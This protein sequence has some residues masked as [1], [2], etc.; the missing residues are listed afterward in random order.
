MKMSMT[1]RAAVAAASI[2]LLLAG[3]AHDPGAPAGNDITD[4]PA[5]TVVAKS[6]AA[7][8]AA[9]SYRVEVHNDEKSLPL[10]LKFAVV[11]T[12]L[13]G[14]VARQGG[15]TEILKVGTNF[16]IRPDE[17]FWRTEF[18][19]AKEAHAYAAFTGTR[20]IKI[21]RDDRWI[22]TGGLDGAFLFADRTF[23]NTAVPKQ[24]ALGARRDINGVPTITVLDSATTL[25]ARTEISV[26]TTGEPYPIRWN[27]GLGAIADFTDFAMTADPI[28]D[29]APADV[30]LRHT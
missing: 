1:K 5:A 29:P 25:P 6:L 19:K 9:P 24:M 11:G 22:D 17:T 8:K 27:F 30:V 4:L 12:N 21:K 16:Y 14:T 3:C 23:L 13:R 15:S 26:A 20:W 18:G 28:E 2:L 10:S 7:F